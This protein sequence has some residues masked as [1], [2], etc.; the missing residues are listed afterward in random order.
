MTLWLYLLLWIISKIMFNRM[1]MV[2]TYL[3]YILLLSN[4][5][6]Y[7]WRVPLHQHDANIMPFSYYNSWELDFYSLQHC[8]SE[9]SRRK[10]ILLWQYYYKEVHIVTILIRKWF[11]NTCLLSLISFQWLNW[12]WECAFWEENCPY[13]DM[14]WCFD[15]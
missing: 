8:L 2:C 12:S 11:M 14:P 1:I 4:K 15:E 9:R 3:I 10:M 5:I 13:H 7:F 6:I